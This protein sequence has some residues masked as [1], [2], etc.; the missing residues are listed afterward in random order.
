MN[1]NRVRTMKTYKYLGVA[2]LLC[3][4]GMIGIMAFGVARGDKG[5]GLPLSR[6]N[7]D[8]ISLKAFVSDN[9]YY[10]PDGYTYNRISVGIIR[11]HDSKPN[12]K[13]I[14]HNGSHSWEL[15]KGK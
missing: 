14:M 13:Y 12:V 11:V 2:V 4:I 15:Y 7:I 10:P 3:V 8:S 1:G 9:D 6:S 5:N